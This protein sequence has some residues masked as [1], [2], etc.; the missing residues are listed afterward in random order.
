MSDQT[1]ERL[2]EEDVFEVCDALKCQ[3]RDVTQQAVLASLGRGSMT[4]VTRVMSLWE[5]GQKAHD[6]DLSA[7][8]GESTLGFGRQMLRTLTER[9]RQ[10][11]AEEAAR[12]TQL[13]EEERR[14]VTEVAQAYDDLVNDSEQRIAQIQTNAARTTEQLHNELDSR[15]TELGQTRQEL[16]HLKT[17]VVDQEK[18][19]AVERDRT[20]YANEMKNWMAKQRDEEMR[21]VG[22][23]QAKEHILS[24]KVSD[25]ELELKNVKDSLLSFELHNK[26]MQRWL[27]D[28]NEKLKNLRLELDVTQQELEKKNQRTIAL[29]IDKAA[30][31]ANLLAFTRQVDDYRG[32]LT[33][34][35]ARVAELIAALQSRA[36]THSKR[37]KATGSRPP[38]S[39]CSG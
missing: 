32:R 10:Q 34:S 27:E 33:V 35:D 28:D 24:V 3:G 26:T 18:K 7:D 6:T 38:M 20:E 11:A 21:I 1:A 36:P 19:L 12:L 23:G 31:E 8:D 9:M 2:T 13:M 15:T 25:L 39:L 29:E 17:L 16:E 14:R 37:T 30:L 5:G 4:T 22:E